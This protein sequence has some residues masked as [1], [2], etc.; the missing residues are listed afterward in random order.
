M[1]TMTANWRFSSRLDARGHVNASL[2]TKAFN[3]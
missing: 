2:E 1:S 3:R